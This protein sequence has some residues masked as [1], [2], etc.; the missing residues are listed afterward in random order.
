MELKPGYKQT[1]VG[2]IPK[3]WTIE[4]ADSIVD[5]TAPICYGVVQVGR[6]VR[7]GV[8]VVAIKYV[9]EIDRGP[10]HRTLA[11]LERPYARSR[12]KSGDVLISV[13]GTIG[14]V[15]VVPEG[16]QGNI[17]RELARL[18]LEKGYW[19]EYVAHQLEN[20]R[21]QERILRSVVGTTRLEFSIA[22]LRKFE[23]AFPPTK[24]EQRAIA[25]ALSDVDTLLDGLER[26]IAKKRDIKQAVMQQ[27]LT[28]ETR[29][30]GYGRAGTGVKTGYKRTEVGEIP[31]DWSLDYIENIANI[32]T[33]S[34][35]TQD[36]VD[37]GQ[38]PF[39]VRSQVVEHINS[40]SF[41]GE[42]VMTS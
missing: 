26:L 10:L 14:R 35:N 6:N 7:N 41:E 40:Y 1:E 42:E 15:G 25:T 19:A 38:Y 4:T 28:G 36:R 23:L 30:P 11:E 24:T 37:D 34:K 3:D 20:N 17:S 16:F 8:P 9:K 12:V 29:L 13:K 2:V 21:T 39:F 22:T 5:P 33:G 32:T 27:L 18:R 31:A